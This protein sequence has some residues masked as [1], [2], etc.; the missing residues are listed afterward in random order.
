MLTSMLIVPSIVMATLPE[1]EFT[2]DALFYAEPDIESEGATPIREF[3]Q[4]ELTIENGEFNTHESGNIVFYR[5]TADG[6]EGWIPA[7]DILFVTVERRGTV[8]TNATLRSEATTNSEQVGGLTAGAE[9]R[10]HP[11]TL[12][13]PLRG[14]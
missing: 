6:S 1:V 5:A 12:V 11:H 10:S 13:I 4:V 9:L 8:N 14:W 7:R 2:D 3:E